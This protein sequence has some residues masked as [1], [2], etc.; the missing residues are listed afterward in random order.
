MVRMFNQLSVCPH[1]NIG[2]EFF[3]GE[4]NGMRNNQALPQY[5]RQVFDYET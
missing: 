5:V 2:H 1:G 4:L 3:Q